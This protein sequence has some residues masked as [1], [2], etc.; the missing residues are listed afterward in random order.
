M[1]IKQNRVSPYYWFTLDTSSAEDMETLQ[2]LRM[3]ISAV[4]KILGT[5]ERVEIRGRKPIQKM[6]SRAK[7]TGKVST[8]GYNSD[9]N[10][11]G[12]IKNASVI[13]VYVYNRNV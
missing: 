13:D 5:N 6:E 2:E 8:V 1:E 7:Y 11:V 4:N 12:G 10:I 9:G 3:K